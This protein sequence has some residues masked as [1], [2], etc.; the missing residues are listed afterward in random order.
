MGGSVLGGGS[1]GGGSNRPLSGAGVRGN[2]GK[3]WKAVK[4]SLLTRVFCIARGCSLGSS[5]PRPREGGGGLVDGGRRSLTLTSGS[6]GSLLRGRLP[7]KEGSLFLSGLCGTGLAGEGV[8]SSGPPSC[9]RTGKNEKLGSLVSTWSGRGLWVT[10]S[11]GG[12]GRLS[13]SLGSRLG[14]SSLIGFLPLE[15]GGGGGLFE[16]GRLGG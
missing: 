15:G 8:L 9:S 12:G 11:G 16:G 13:G 6:C 1:V 14:G 3:L 5:R 4:G 10:G 2:C 7:S